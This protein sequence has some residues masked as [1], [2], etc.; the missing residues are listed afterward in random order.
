MNHPS[1]IVTNTHRVD[2]SSSCFRAEVIK[3]NQKEE[4]DKENF[5]ARGRGS[6]FRRKSSSRRAKSLGKDHWDEVM[7]GE[8]LIASLA[9]NTQSFFFVF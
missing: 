8:L 3:S 9:S 1:R 6:L 4:N 7:F 2:F 5:P